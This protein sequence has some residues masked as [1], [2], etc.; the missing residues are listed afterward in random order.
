MYFDFG[1]RR[2]IFSRIATGF[3]ELRLFK[4]SSTEAQLSI[5]STV[6]F[7]ILFTIFFFAVAK[8]NFCSRI[9]FVRDARDSDAHKP[10]ILLHLGSRASWQ[11][12]NFT[13][14]T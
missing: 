1:T 8:Q 14:A 13:R 4:D 7:A 10:W 12:Q 5:H 2:M 11:G 9:V 3:A 6:P